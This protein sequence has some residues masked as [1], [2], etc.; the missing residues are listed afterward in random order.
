[1]VHQS[2]RFGWILDPVSMDIKWRQSAVLGWKRA[3]LLLFGGFTC[4]N[5]GY[6]G[7]RYI[8]DIHIWLVLS[9]E[10]M[11][12]RWPFSLL[13]DEQMSNWV[14]VKHL[15]DKLIH[16][17][18]SPLKLKLTHVVFAGVSKLPSFVVI[19]Q[20]KHVWKFWETYI[21]FIVQCLAWENIN[22]PCLSHQF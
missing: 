15:P 7:S 8:I 10:Q 14:G 12:K 11:S 18:S 19:K 6:W 3:N 1:M 4:N 5:R 13:N 2:F 17:C 21:L 20:C 16:H 9:D 22:G